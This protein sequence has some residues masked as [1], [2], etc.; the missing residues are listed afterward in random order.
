MKGLII[1]ILSF[2]A[3]NAFPQQVDLEKKAQEITEEGK[4][5]YRLEMAAWHGTDIFLES[6]KEKARI[7]GYFTYIEKDTPKCLFFSKGENAKVIG[8]VS[9]GDIK[10]VE[11]ATIDF[12]ERDFKQ[13]EKELYTMRTTAL[14]EIQQDTLFKKYTNASFNLIPVIYKDE[15][16]VYVLT[17]PKKEGVV[18]FGNDYLL[19]FDKQENLIEKKEIHRNLIPIKFELEDQDE[20]KKIVAS[21]HSHAAGT[22]EFI[23]PTDICTLMLYGKFTGWKRHFVISENYVSVWD[24]VNES[25]VIMTTEEY[26]RMRDEEKYG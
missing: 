19:A 3:I 15:R 16:K 13:D 22:G 21:V 14:Q 4:Y 24:C 23:T 6:F 9:F 8:V 20:S 12:K 25:L 26:E 11:T 2:F 18:L 5:L 10:V 17:G 1:I 7:G